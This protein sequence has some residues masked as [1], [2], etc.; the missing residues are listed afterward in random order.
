MRSLALALGFGLLAGCTPAQLHVAQSFAYGVQAEHD[1]QL[2]RQ[3]AE[4]CPVECFDWPD[5]IRCEPRC[6]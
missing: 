6:P 5:G 1:A 3:A 4:P 2:Y